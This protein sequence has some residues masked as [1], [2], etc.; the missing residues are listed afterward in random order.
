MAVD[1]TLPVE[2]EQPQVEVA[3]VV[4]ATYVEEPTTTKKK[5]RKRKYSR[6]TKDLQRLERGMTR[7]SS[8][9]AEAVAKG[10]R[11][12]NKESKK[13]GRRKRDGAMRDA[14]ENATLALADSAGEAAKA[15]YEIARKI[16]GKLVWRRSRA[17]GRM[18][19][20]LLFR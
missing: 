10:F 7:A 12:Y 14:L 11:T 13:S 20:P 9:V 8:R 15:P 5:R 4:V 2:T 3:P 1:K 19:A 17:T 16:N 18:V 6:G